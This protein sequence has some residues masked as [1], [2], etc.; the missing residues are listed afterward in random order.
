MCGGITFRYDPLIDQELSGFYDPEEL[1]RFREAGLIES[2]YWQPRPVLPAVL[3]DGDFQLLEWGNR[4]GGLDLPRTGWVRQESLRQG[5]WDWLRPRPLL[6]PATRGYEKRHWFGVRRGIRGLLAERDGERR[7]FMLT[8]DA[9]PRYLALTGHPRMPLLVDQ[10]DLDEVQSPKS[11]V[12]SP[13]RGYGVEGPKSKAQ[14]RES[15][16]PPSPSGRGRGEGRPAE[17]LALDLW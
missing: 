10:D 4:D 11:K 14:R 9:T 1:A 13:G 5:R 7:V 8:R 17:Q 2:Y 12:Q 15:R 3:D 6:I 16:E